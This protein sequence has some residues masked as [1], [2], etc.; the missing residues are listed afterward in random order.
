MNR[1]RIA[2]EDA[3]LVLSSRE[4]AR[5]QI[6]SLNSLFEE[7]I[8]FEALISRTKF[9]YLN[10]EL[11]RAIIDIVE[12]AVCYADLDK[13]SIHDTVLVGESTRIPKVQRLLQD[14][15]NGKKLQNISYPFGKF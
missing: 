6:N 15:F 13:N 8:I 9:E 11:F 12:K 5:I 2:C 4:S 3:K 1:L 10:A 14:F 7:S